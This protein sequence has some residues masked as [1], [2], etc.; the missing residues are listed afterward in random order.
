MIHNERQDVGRSPSDENRTEDQDLEHGLLQ[1]EENAVA[2][3]EAADQA[4]KE[5]VSALRDFWQEIREVRKVLS[6]QTTQT[7][8]D[9]LLG[10]RRGP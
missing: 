8:W 2:M 3:I 5:A 10:P 7:T 6:N 1:R 4:N 9:D